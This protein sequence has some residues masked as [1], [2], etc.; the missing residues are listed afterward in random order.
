MVLSK[1]R[2][3]KRAGIFFV[4]DKQGVID[5]Y[6][7]YLLRD[8]KENLNYL[9]VVVNGVLSEDGRKTLSAVTPN[10]FVRDNVG[11]DAWAYKEGLEYIGWKRLAEYDEVVLAN[12][13]NFGPVY[14]F[15]EAFD[16]MN[17]RD[18]DFWGLTK[19]YGLNFDPYK[20]CKY[21][22]V[23]AHIQ[24]SF[25][26][27]RKSMLMSS[28]FRQFWDSLPLI[29]S[30]DESVCYHE[31]ILTK[32]FEDKGYKSDV[33]INAS[34]LAQYQEYPLM[35]Y[36]LELV[37]NR[38]CPVFKRKSFFNI[39]GEFL[40]VSCGQSTWELYNYLANETNY[41][42]GMIWESILRTCNL[43]DVKNRTSLISLCPQRYDILM[44]VTQR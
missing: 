43:E 25:I 11:F 20:I 29:Q 12:Y 10:I 19:H 40:G 35:L 23:P 13:T 39:Y 7:P 4:F 22:Y 38:R 33:Y 26:V 6:I 1:K 36:P 2:F 42:V 16:A 8:L 27:I 9:L 15:R 41:D 31:V 14:P 24:A 5:S 32:D 30:Y 28:D 18:V 17:G 34:D 21:G 3:P 37:R 44:I